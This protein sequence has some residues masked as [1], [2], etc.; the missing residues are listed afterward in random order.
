MINK[1]NIC[2]LRQCFTNIM[3]L[4]KITSNDKKKT[5]I[6]LSYVAK[7]DCIRSHFFY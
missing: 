5:K 2:K 3:K 4:N 7:I 6:T 1:K